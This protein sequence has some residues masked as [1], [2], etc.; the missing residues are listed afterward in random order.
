[1]ALTASVTLVNS[2]VQ[3]IILFQNKVQQNSAQASA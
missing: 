2:N 3:K 1:M